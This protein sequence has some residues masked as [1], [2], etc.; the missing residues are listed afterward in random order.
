[1][2]TIQ[3]C[4]NFSIH[5]IDFKKYSNKGFI[6]RQTLI[7]CVC[8]GTRIGGGIKCS[9]HARVDDGYLTCTYIRKFERVRLIPYMKRMLKYGIDKVKTAN[10][11]NCKKICLKLQ[12]PLYEVDGQLKKDTNILKITIVSKKLKFVA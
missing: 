7:F 11:F 4:L 9:N 2:A 8:N 5:D 1:M 3:K 12:R 6:H 10:K